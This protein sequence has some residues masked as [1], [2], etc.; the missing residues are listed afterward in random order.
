MIHFGEMG[1]FRLTDSR[2]SLVLKRI[3]PAYCYN[4][5]TLLKVDNELQTSVIICLIPKTERVVKARNKRWF[6]SA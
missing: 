3:R 4:T 2:I 1:T 5:N 6:M